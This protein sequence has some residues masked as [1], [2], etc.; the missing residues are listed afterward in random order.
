MK[1]VALVLALGAGLASGPAVEKAGAA[2]AGGFNGTW[3]VELVTDSG[4]CD[5]RYRYS[6]AVNEGSVQLVSASDGA[7]M[8]GRVGSDGTVGL[9]VSNGTASGA[10]SGR[11][12][13]QTGSGTWKVSALCSGRWT[14]RRQNTRTAQAE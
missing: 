14:A 5:S 9:S 13:A 10:V 11:L 3:S 2:E 6:V 4:L 8:S 7:R 1:H 12:L